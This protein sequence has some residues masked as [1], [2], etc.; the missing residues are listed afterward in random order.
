MI[1]SWETDEAYPRTGEITEFSGGVWMRITWRKTA[2]GEHITL[3]VEKPAE[4]PAAG[5]KEGERVITLAPGPVSRMRRR[6]TGDTGRCSKLLLKGSHSGGGRRCTSK[7]GGRSK[8]EGPGIDKCEKE[9]C[10]IW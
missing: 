7:A 3:P 4:D 6:S 5:Q 1:Y 8:A 10:A 2:E 9:P